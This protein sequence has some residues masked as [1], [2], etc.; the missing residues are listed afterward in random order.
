MYRKLDTRNV[1]ETVL[2]QKVQNIAIIISYNI[3]M[4]INHAANIVNNKIP[5]QKHTFY[6]H[7]ELFIK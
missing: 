2:F 5:K 1:D 6:F 3:L 7:S 4:A